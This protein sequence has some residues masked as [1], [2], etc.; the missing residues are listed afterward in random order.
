MTTHTLAA[1]PETV[2][3]G[4]F[5]A[6]FAPV[7]TIA[8]GDTVRVQCVSGRASVMPPPGSDLH[9]PEALAAIVAANPD[10]PP[11]H[12]V[13][14]PIAITG[15]EPGD[16]LEIRIDTIEIGADWGLQ[17]DPAA[18]GH[19]SGRLPRDGADAHPGRQGARR[20]HAALGH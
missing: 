4:Q 5:D 14:G 11:G 8:S 19:A 7:L 2:R 10:P 17:R 6:S 15:A 16:T 13:T 1:T 20:V 9:V 18:R 12:I 3:I